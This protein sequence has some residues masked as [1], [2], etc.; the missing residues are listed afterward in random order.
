MI[1]DFLK[2]FLDF[3]RYLISAEKIMI[4]DS[5]SCCFCSNLCSVGQ[6]LLIQIIGIYIIQY[7]RGSHWWALSLFIQMCFKVA[8]LIIQRWQAVSYP[9]CQKLA[10]LPCVGE[11]DEGQVNSRFNIFQ[12]PTLSA[13]HGMN[14]FHIRPSA[15]SAVCWGNTPGMWTSR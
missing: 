7:W 5:L 2:T 15:R 11:D 8:G 14:I 13:R 1:A 10:C 12:L 6:V 3:S 9:C 4:P